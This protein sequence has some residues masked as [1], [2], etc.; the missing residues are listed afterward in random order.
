VK[1]NKEADDDE[2][3]TEEQLEEPKPSTSE[4]EVY[5]E[6]DTKE[7]KPPE[8]TE[9]D[10]QNISQNEITLD[11]K[12]TLN[13]E[14]IICDEKAEEARELNMVGEHD[15]DRINGNELGGGSNKIVEANKENIGE[16]C[17]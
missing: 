14:V 5:S 2:V 4:E 8:E 12:E 16:V 11:S 6:R 3:V 1:Q 15:K 17:N 13:N 10:E 9:E 7:S